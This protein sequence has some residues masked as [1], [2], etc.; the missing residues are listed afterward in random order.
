MG[1]FG[2]YFKKTLRWP[3]LASPGPLSMLVDGGASVLDIA[4]DHIMWL[5]N[6]FAPA[7][8]EDEFL[9]HF[10]RSRGVR[11]APLET[12]EH[13][14][15]RVR[16]AYLWWSRGGRA[17]SLE[18]TLVR[19]FGFASVTVESLRDEDPDRW[20]EFR[21]VLDVQG[22]DLTMGFEHSEWAI[23]EI[24]PAR[25]KLAGINIRREQA[26]PLYLAAALHGSERISIE[27]W[28]ITELSASGTL[29]VGAAL[30]HTA[31]VSIY[32]TSWVPQDATMVDGLAKLYV[33]VALLQLE[34]I[35]VYPLQ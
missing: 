35:D 15:A 17:S 4:R 1:V 6:Q 32:P 22:S 7:L 24:K 26:S 14:Q 29:T 12:E 25:S 28:A 11:R 13:Y 10:A 16:A 21:V 31:I 19:Y 34:T 30:Q 2:D 23:N 8:C 33:A 20:A 27:P 9:I 3:L 18:Q 5:R